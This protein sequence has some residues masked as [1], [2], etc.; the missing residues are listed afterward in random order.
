MQNPFSLPLSECVLRIAIALSFLYPPLAALTDPYSWSGYFPSF[1]TAILG[2]NTLL[3]LHAFGIVEVAIALWVLFGK[4]ILIPSILAALMLLAIV[5][6]NLA[7]FPILFRDIS[8]ALAALA[9]AFMHRP[10]GT[11]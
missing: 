9:L 8:I 6:F 3:F 4:R 1:L 7:Q 2:T 5:G 11:N 10:H